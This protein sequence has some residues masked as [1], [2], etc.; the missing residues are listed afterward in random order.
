MPIARWSKWR[1]GVSVAIVLCGGTGDDERDKDAASQ[2]AMKEAGALVTTPNNDKNL[3]PRTCLSAT[4]VMQGLRR[5]KHASV[6]RQSSHR[7]TGGLPSLLPG[8]IH[9]TTTASSCCATAGLGP[10]Y[11][12]VVYDMFFLP[13]SN[14]LGILG[15]KG[16]QKGKKVYMI[17]LLAGRPVW[18]LIE[19][20]SRG[21]SRPLFHE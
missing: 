2:Q 21:K 11:E 1:E 13:F 15:G 9:Q 16:H 6:A 5:D 7:T 10:R 3:R 18:H 19:Y 14:L 4:C 8:S 20:R 17:R 12:G